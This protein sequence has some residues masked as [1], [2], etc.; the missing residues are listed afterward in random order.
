MQAKE[1]GKEVKVGALVLLGVVVFGAFIF[2]LGDCSLT[3][4]YPIYVDFTD[5]AG[6]KAGAEVRVSGIRAGNVRTIEFRGGQMDA[7]V[8]RPVFVR[9]HVF[10]EES[11]AS[12][13]RQDARF[14][15]TTQGVLG[16]P[17]IAIHS[18]DPAA[19]PASRGQIF[20]GTDPP[21]LEQLIATAYEGL[22]GVQGLVE[23]LTETLGSETLELEA[24]INNIGSLAGALNERVR[25]NEGHIDSIF[26]NVDGLLV[27]SRHRLPQLLDNADGAVREAEQLARSLNN[28]VR[29]GSELR[30]V[31]RNTREVSAVAAREIEPLMVSVRETADTARRVVTDNEQDI[32]RTVQNAEA[33][34]VSA[35]GAVDDVRTV[36]GRIE[37]GEGTVGRLLAD[38]EI[39][40]DMREFVREL[41]RRPWRIIWK[42]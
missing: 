32:R 38:E 25:A 31:I 35:R 11:M 15:I 27:D 1:S 21:R 5:A 3:R 28:A 9:A 26:E 10:L 18:T 24:F 37:R 2:L 4:Q 8:G 16:E 39:F 17:Y 29:D 33:L 42:E 36:V 13:V 20:L 40:D 6:L 7:E 34:A 41:K 23:R 30:A 19:P 22:Q 12:Y 14:T